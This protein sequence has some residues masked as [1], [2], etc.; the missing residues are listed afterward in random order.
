MNK[1][2]ECGRSREG[3]KEVKKD[4]PGKRSEEGKKRY[5]VDKME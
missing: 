4:K 5:E 1:Q 3:E 2:R